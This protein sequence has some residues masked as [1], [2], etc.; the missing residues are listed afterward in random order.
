MREIRNVGQ[1]GSWRDHVKCGVMELRRTC[2][3]IE[4]HR[5]AMATWAFVALRNFLSLCTWSGSR[6]ILG[7]RGRRKRIDL[8]ASQQAVNRCGS[9][10]VV[11]SICDV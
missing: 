6:A 9:G 11:R 8:G 2:S 10:N 4:N 1:E 5:A 7:A 3:Y